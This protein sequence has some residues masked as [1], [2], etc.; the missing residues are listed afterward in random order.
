[1]MRTV[2]I[3]VLVVLTLLVIF[4]LL[5]RVGWNPLDHLATM[6][7]TAGS[8]TTGMA[9]TTGSAPTA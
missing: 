9:P 1:M 3:V 6:R 2:G 7:T 4:A 8:T 5:T